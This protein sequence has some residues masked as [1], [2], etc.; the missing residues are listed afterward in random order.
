MAAAGF[1]YGLMSAAPHADPPSANRLREPT[2]NQTEPLSMGGALAIASCANRALIARS[3]QR[4]DRG[5]VARMVC[6]GSVGQPSALNSDPSGGSPAVGC[7]SPSGLAGGMG[8]GSEG[9]G[10]GFGS[11]GVGF[12]SLLT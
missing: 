12:G 1:L 10:I 4:G 7:G 8:G 11:D 3:T 5:F 9:S 6:P 2:S